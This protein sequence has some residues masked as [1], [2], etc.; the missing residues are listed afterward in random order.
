M[1]SDKD[2]CCFCIPLPVGVVIIGCTILMELLGALA[3]KN[4]WTIFVTIAMF[5]IFIITAS[6][7][8]N[9]CARRVLAYGYATVFILE[10]VI[11]TLLVMAFYKD[12]YPLAYC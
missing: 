8:N 1:Y 2:T 12:N 4:G 9:L 10:V 6:F 11:N 7:R 3:E 5:I